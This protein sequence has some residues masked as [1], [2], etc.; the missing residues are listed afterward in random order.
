MRLLLLLLS[1]P[2][3]AQT[4]APK[5]ESPKPSPARP[6]PDET[7]VVRKHEL[8]LGGRTL[9]YT[10]TTGR[11]PIRDAKGETEAHIFYIAYT[12]DGVADPGKRRLMFSFNG[13]PG[14]ASV[15]LH[16]GAIGPKR[17]PM[18]DDG[19]MPAPPFQLAANDATLLD[20]ADLVFIDPVGTGYSRPV[21]PEL[22]QKFSSRQGDLESVGEFIR[23]YLTRNRRW[24]SPL[25]LIGES[26]GTTRAAGLAG[27]LID[28]GI[29]F[30]GIALVSTILN[31][32]TSRFARG[33]DLPF[34]LLLPTYTATAWHHKRLPADLQKMDLRKLL[35][36][37]EAWALTGYSEALSL[38]D[39]MT[40]AQR[41][42][43]VDRLARYTGLDP[44]YVDQADLR[45]ALPYFN[46]ELLRDRNQMVGRLD[47]RLTG[48]GPRDLSATYEF[49]PSMAA[50][51]PPYTAAFYQYVRAELGY[52]SDLDYYILGGGVGRWNMNA[53]NEYA[54][55]SESL[56]RA[57]A[58][59]PFLKVY[60]GAGYYD[61][62]TPY[63]AATYTLDHMGLPASL[64]SNIR[65]HEY[66]AG[67]MYYIQAESLKAMKRDLSAFLDWA[68]PL[69]P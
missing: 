18:R 27:Y 66:P 24:L 54:D 62:A 1:L 46:R 43:A 50:I 10:T 11:M 32:Q 25:L 38:G 53:E 6:A 58:R 35:S 4:P 45:I 17:V 20:E 42:A 49:D 14:S 36:E 52:E 22:Q 57:F 21:K 9:L 48:P 29:A 40:P 30:N 63:F 69:A 33:N 2:L 65:V 28:R 64:R 68:A 26:Y 3:L 23:L 13:G 60:L 61:M 19:A 56:R 59:N 55:V 34:P 8:S 51:R 39:R 44:K 41:K 15:W 67:H 7:P 5:P 16:L 12:L 37:V 47:S 31:F